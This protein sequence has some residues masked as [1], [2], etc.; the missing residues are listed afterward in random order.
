[1]SDSL[2]Y[3]I[4]S[5]DVY[6]R[7]SSVRM[8]VF[9][10]DGVLTDGRLTLSSAGDEAKRFHIHDGLGIVLAQKSGLH[11]ALMSGRTSP[12]VERR[13]KELGIRSHLVISDARDKE[14]A[15]KELK[16]RLDLP[17]EAV[18]FVGDDL[19]DLPAFKEV[20]LAVAVADAVTEVAARCHVV[21][22]AKGG[23]GAAREIIERVLCAQGKWEEAIQNYLQFLRED[24]SGP[25]PSSPQ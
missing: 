7:L 19:N 4:P 18:A 16:L 13:A 21:T 5:E 11:I 2:S 10:V 25:H 6:R 14:R 3:T 12:A 8:I 23:E 15:I 20:G 22:R 17:A 24:A 9:D 1:M